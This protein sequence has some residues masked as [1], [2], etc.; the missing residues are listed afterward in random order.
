VRR[1]LGI[2]EQEARRFEGSRSWRWTAPL[3]GAAGAIRSI[4]GGALGLASVVSG[5]L[6][7]PGADRLRV[8]AR[9]ELIKRS[10]YFNADWYRARYPDV[11]SAGVDLAWHFAARGSV[12]RRDPGPRFST[13]YYLDSNPDVDASGEHA[14]EHYLTT[15]ISEGRRPLPPGPDESPAGRGSQPGPSDAEA[16]PAIQ[17]NGPARSVEMPRVDAERLARTRAI[18]FYLPQFH[19]IPENDAWWGRGFT[20]WSNVT[21]S[22]ALFPGHA[23]PMLPSELGFYDLRVPEVREQQ[24]ELAK[25]AGIHGFCYYHYWFNGRRVLDR[26][27]DDVLH[28]GAPDLPFCV[29][30]ANENWTRRWDGLEQEILLRQRH[31]L[32]SD[33]EFMLDLLPYLEDERYIR[34]D[35]KP[36]VLVY[37]PDLM[38]NAADTAAVWRDECRHAGLGDVHL[39]AVQFRT[40]DPGPLGFDAAVEFPPHHF[41]AP[42]ITKSVRG[43]PEGFE[44]A[45]MDYRAGVEALLARP[46]E[47]T[48]R[49]YRGVMPSWDNTA[50]RLNAATIHHGSTPALYEAWLRSAINHDQPGGPAGES[51]VFINA[52]NEWAEGAVLEPRRDI[53]DAYL[54]A[55]ARALGRPM[56]DGTPHAASAPP[57]A[58]HTPRPD[59]TP[60]VGSVLESKI[61]R[62]V[63]T[64]PRLNAFVNRHPDLK[65]RAAGIVR[66]IG[67]Q[68]HAEPG[69]AVL[70]GSAPAPRSVSWRGER[71]PDR[72]DAPKL[73]VVSHDAALAGAQLIVLENVRHWADAGVDC[74][75]LLLGSGPLETEFARACPTAC[76]DDLRGL[77]RPRAIRAGLDDLGSRGW[78]PDAAFCNTV[79]SVDAIDE[80]RRRRV[81]VASAVYEL[82]TSIDDALGGSRTIHRVIAGS[83][84][85]VVAS[86]FVRDR[87]AAAYG[88]DPGRLEA[89]HTG[90]LPRRVPEPSDARAGIRKELGVPAD[91]PI[92]LG[93]GSIHHRKGTDLFVSAAAE[94]VRVRRAKPEST[95]A[96]ALFVWVGE[97]QSGATFGNWCRHDAERL[98]VAEHIRFVGPDTD[99]ARWFAG[100]DVFAL[101]SREDPYPMVNLEAINAGLPVVAFEGGGGAP[102]ILTPNGIGATVPYADPRA[103]G[104][105]LARFL[106]A[107]DEADAERD[108]IRAFAR[109]SLGWGNYMDQ[110]NDRLSDCSAAFSALAREHAS[111]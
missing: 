53:G 23:Q 58:D 36:V 8:R 42:E 97:D 78:V 47:P 111:G 3:R 86:G 70:N 84:R 18:A 105:A 95:A 34:M 101:T 60:R 33:R 96:R 31:S 73:L 79:A 89:V 81:P 91:T 51:L 52:W 64:N 99:P 40:S 69:G 106:D 45:V 11:A 24:A 94:T 57:R 44:G 38:H 1:S 71:V 6:R 20:E 32:A 74:R 83:R 27:L 109:R 10:G 39:C 90:V 4:A 82:P 55:T 62:A 17:V 88:L 13:S 110:L 19:P 16:A 5:A 103:F 92:V 28:H 98:G 48:Y 29:C 80:L 2:A 26:P 49:L 65:N 37:R 85:I 107:S 59:A 87:L 12:E 108:R 68:A 21:R 14:F 67:S 93:C 46:H 43:L 100:A 76:L 54:R 9:A 104:S 72:P 7:L 77:A 61:K 25:A 63:R 50:R 66:K 102:E 22:R 75:V 41:P 15:G 35:G 56:P 30:W